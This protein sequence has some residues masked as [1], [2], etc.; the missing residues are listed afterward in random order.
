M[1]LFRSPIIITMYCIVLAVA[2]TTPGCGMFPSKDGIIGQVVETGNSYRSEMVTPTGKFSD[3]QVYRDA[4]TDAVVFE[5]KMKPGLQFDQA[6][7][8]SDQFKADL[9]AQLDTADSRSALGSGIDFVFLYAD[10]NGNTICRHSITN[11][12]F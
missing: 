1:A 6:T 4:E 7:A 8:R 3:Y 11:A 9:V 2:L 10:A 5:H 12:D